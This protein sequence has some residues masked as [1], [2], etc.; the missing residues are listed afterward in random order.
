M[1]MLQSTLSFH[2]G[3]MDRQNEGQSDPYV[4]P[5]LQNGDSKRPQGLNSMLV[6][7]QAV[8]F[9]CNILL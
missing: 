8:S 2:D 5:F 7:S 9:Y 4:R 3:P 6:D 1:A